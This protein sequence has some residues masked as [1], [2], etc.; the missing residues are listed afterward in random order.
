MIYILLYI[1]S[2]FSSAQIITEFQAIQND[3][4]P[5]WIEIYNKQDE[6]IFI[7]T[8][9]I[10]DSKSS[11]EYYN[12]EIKRNSFVVFTSNKSLLENKYIINSESIIEIKLATLNNT[13]DEIK[14]YDNN[15]LIDSLYYDYKWFNNSNSVERVDFQKSASKENLKSSLNSFGGTPLEF[16]SYKVFDFDLSLI[17]IVEL[18]GVIKVEI[19]N[20]GRDTITS[21]DY[22]VYL[23]LDR[24]NKYDSKEVVTSQI[25]NK[26]D[27]VITLNFMKYDLK[28]DFDIFGVFSILIR[29]N[30]DK[31]EYIEND[32]I[33]LTVNF[34]PKKESILINEFMFDVYEDN[35]EFIEI[36]NNSEFDINI[37]NLYLTDDISGKKNGIK[38]DVDYVLKSKDLFVIAADSL[39]LDFYKSSLLPEKVFIAN[40]NLSLNNG[41]D[42]IILK[43]EDGFVIDELEYYPAWHSSSVFDTKNISLEK[44]ESNLI[45]SDKENW[46]SS[47]DQN[48]ATPTFANSFTY[49]EKRDFGLLIPK[50]PFSFLEENLLKIAYISPFENS[51]INLTVFS[52]DGVKLGM[53]SELSLGGA[54]GE[55]IW[56][57][58]LNNK[59]VKTGSY[60]LYFESIK[61]DTQE[62]Y[63]SKELLV[64]VN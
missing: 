40:K 32:T 49:G 37:N 59:K 56:D 8:F 62:I 26:I 58:T 9:R 17:N 13:T 24:N 10:A 4:E 14:I 45:S 15:T 42:N 23:D 53:V 20:D 2:S 27:S 54:K 3:Y 1:I 34:A 25:D 41:G 55:I 61:S 64:I 11:V 5:E 60:I 18:D 43:W 46:I 30:S 12:L 48:G 51:N 22:E 39:I 44:K 19:I 47:T 7:D 16:N 31:D 6:D 50:N 21:F 33:T 29:I 35:C 63:T 36:Y 38:F 57:G 28:Q 52:K